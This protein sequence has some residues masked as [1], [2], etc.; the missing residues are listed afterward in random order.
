MSTACMHLADPLRPL[1]LSPLRS[2]SLSLSPRSLSRLSLL[3]RSRSLLWLRSL[4]PA[5]SLLR[6]RLLPLCLSPSLSLRH[7]CLVCRPGRW[8]HC[9]TYC[10]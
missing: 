10:L 9:Q 6:L 3:R 2:L 1:S 7:A 4:S 8:G 5:R